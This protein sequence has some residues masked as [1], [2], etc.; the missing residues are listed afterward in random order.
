VK[1]S[2]FQHSKICNLFNQQQIKKPLARCVSRYSHSLVPSHMLIRFLIISVVADDERTPPFAA[3]K[4]NLKA[5]QRAARPPPSP[6]L[7]LNWTPDT[8]FAQSPLRH[9]VEEQDD[10]DTVAES[11]VPFPR[12]GRLCCWL[13]FSHITCTAFSRSTRRTG[14]KAKKKK[15]R[16]QMRA[17]TRP[18]SHRTLYE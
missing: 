8:S 6:S 14:S 18:T 16:K 12:L 5:L 7:S 15:K 1:R 2:T 9:N 10:H 4:S 17:M 11:M 13:E 3:A